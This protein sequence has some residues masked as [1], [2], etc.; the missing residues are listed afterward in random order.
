MNGIVV[1]GMLLAAA[2]CASFYLASPN[3]YWLGESWPVWPARIA[4]VLLLLAGLVALLN[5]F[6]PAAGS[7]IFLHWLMLLFVLFPYLGALRLALRRGQ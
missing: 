2:G 4:G 1:L 3:Q 6:Q 7:F 5:V